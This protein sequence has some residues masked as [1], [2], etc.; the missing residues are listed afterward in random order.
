MKNPK[1]IAIVF[2]LTFLMF[3]NI[4]A[5]AEARPVNI[6]IILDTSDRISDEQH[7][8]QIE[9]DKEIIEEIVT[10]FAK[11]TKRHILASEKLEYQDRLTIAIPN[12]PG[13]PP[14]PRQIMKD[15]A[16][17]DKNRDS[18]RTL[19]GIN[20]DVENRKQ[21]FLNTLDTLYEFVRQHRHTGSDIWEWFKY[22]AESY[23]SESHQN[24]IICISD[25]Y[26]IFDN[27]IE[28]M[29]IPRT[30]MRV[31]EL[32]DDPQWEQK[33]QGGEGLLTIG[34]DFS[35]YNIDFLMSEIQLQTD[36]NKV[37]YQKDFQI[38]TLYWEVW[39]KSM[40]IKSTNFGKVGHPVGQKIRNL[41][42]QG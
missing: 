31:K 28:D 5:S 16:I 23:F 8:G 9:R 25:G 11:V 10:E 15:L 40:K 27:I 13:V 21:V 12:Q 30:Y 17:A 36:E 39:L 4:G 42:E 18:H 26:L 29:R 35:R 3:L 37:P 22:E 6:V 14:V 20:A 7:P 1:T 19:A 33:I 32:R 34:Q 24:I 41:I 38:I 2:Y